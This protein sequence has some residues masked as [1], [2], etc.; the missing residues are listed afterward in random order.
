M[1]IVNKNELQERR[2]RRNIDLYLWYLFVS[3]AYVHLTL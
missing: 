1:L 2:G 3:D